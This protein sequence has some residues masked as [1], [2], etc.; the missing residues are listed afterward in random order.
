MASSWVLGCSSRVTPVGEKIVR[1]IEPGDGPHLDRRHHHP[2]V[3]KVHDELAGDGFHRVPFMAVGHA[4]AN[5]E[6]AGFDQRVLHAGHLLL[7][8]LQ[9]FADGCRTHTFGPQVTHFHELKQIE[10]GECVGNGDESC[11]LP[12]SQLAGRDVQDPKDVRST[13]SI[14]VGSARIAAELA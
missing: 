3:G 4:R 5:A 10:E 7:H 6:S 14:H 8:G 13:K 9:R 1:R 11:F 12:A 2:R